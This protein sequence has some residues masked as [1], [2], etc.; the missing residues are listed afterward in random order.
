MDWTGAKLCALAQSRCSMSLR[1]KSFSQSGSGAVMTT[2]HSS[3]IDVGDAFALDQP[4][5][6]LLRFLADLARRG[7]AAHDPPV[8]TEPARPGAPNRARNGHEMMKGPRD[9]HLAVLEKYRASCAFSLGA[10]VGNRTRTISLGS[11]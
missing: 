1:L 7:P 11:C 10:G 2:S 5:H 8:E 3:V 6:G 4:G 9:H